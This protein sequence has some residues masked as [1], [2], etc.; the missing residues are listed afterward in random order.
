MLDDQFRCLTKVRRVQRAA[1]IAEWEHACEECQAKGMECP[2]KPQGPRHK[3]R[4]AD[5]MTVIEA[6]NL[7]QS[8]D[9]TGGMRTRTLMPRIVIE[10]HDLRSL[11][12]RVDTQMNV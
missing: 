1:D 2:K 11:G 10:G 6:E 8:I 7:P 3:A 12:V 4:P 9:E 5:L